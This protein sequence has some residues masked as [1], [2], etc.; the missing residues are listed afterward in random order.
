MK[1]APRK[2]YLHDQGRAIAVLG[3]VKTFAWGLMLVIEE[4]DMTGHSI[5]CVTVNHSDADTWTEIGETEFIQ[6]FN[7]KKDPNAAVEEVTE[8]DGRVLN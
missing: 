7:T 8:N 5:S 1:F 3:T 2:F 6:H 4:T